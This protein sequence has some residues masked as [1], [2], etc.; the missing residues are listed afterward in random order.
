[1]HVGPLCQWALFYVLASSPL[2]GVVSCDW[3]VYAVTG[4]CS[5]IPAFLCVRPY[6]VHHQAVCMRVPFTWGLQ[7]WPAKH[8]LR[9]LI[10]HI[11]L[12]Y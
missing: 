8:G 3:W 1:M 2:F 9:S 4:G 11:I 5:A 6:Y 7:A 12:Y 10:P